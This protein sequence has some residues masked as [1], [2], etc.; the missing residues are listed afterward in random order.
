M[1]Y[2]TTGKNNLLGAIGATHVSLHTG[3][4]NDSG[5][6]EATGGAPAYARKSLTLNAA[7]GGTRTHSN[8]P[9]FDVPSGTYFYVGYWDAL[10]VGNFLG[11]G[12]INGGGVDGV[13]LGENTGDVLTSASHGLANDDRI[14]L[15]APSGQTLPT[16]LNETT[17]YHVV[18]V[19]GN[20]F[21]VSLTQAG[22]AVAITADGMAYF[23]KVIPETYG[24][25][26]TLQLDSGTLKVE[27]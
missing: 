7:S 16:G 1:P 11:Y 12:P 25:Q 24:A 3:I 8:T 26:G 6:N 20:T 14:T 21:Q 27:E 19:S 17:I 18:G 5:S 15:K 10:T 13:A 22:A 2:S 23:Q 4:P 9:S